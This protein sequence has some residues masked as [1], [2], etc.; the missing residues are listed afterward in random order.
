M[1]RGILSIAV[2]CCLMTLVAEAQILKGLGDKLNKANREVDKAS[3]I[4]KQ[5]TIDEQDEI[6]IGEQVSAKI[7]AKYG[8][9]QDPQVHKYAG[10]VGMVLA[11]KSS[12]PNLPWQFIVLDTDG[13]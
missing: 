8:V 13:V 2:L 4:A 1:R 10:L 6:T 7:R 3:A 11:K 9:A 12:R 5:L